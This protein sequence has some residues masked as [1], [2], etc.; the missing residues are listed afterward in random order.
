MKA[1]KRLRD[2]LGRADR[3]NCPWPGE[4]LIDRAGAP[5]QIILWGSGLL[6]QSLVEAAA[7]N[8]RSRHGWDVYAQ[9]RD[10]H[11]GH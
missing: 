1:A 2:R 4:E 7:T 11:G 3:T 8:D 9:D 5:D 6:R 10:S